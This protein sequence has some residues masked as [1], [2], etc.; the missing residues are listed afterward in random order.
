MSS[1]VGDLPVDEFAA[2]LARGGLAVRIGPFDLRVGARA[3][4]L[5]APLH[6]LYRDYPL[7]DGER[8]LHGH[9][10]VRDVLRWL[11][12]PRRRVRF[13]VDGRAP[14]EDMPAGQALPVLE[15][16]INLVVALRYHCYLMLHAAVLE[17]GGQALLLPAWPGH[18]KTTLCAALAHRGWRLLSDEFGL[19]RPGTRAL[20]PV[21]RPMPLK[22]ESIDVIR[23]FAPEAFLG[24]TIAGTRKGTIAHVRPPAGSVAR[25]QEVAPA[26]WIVFPRWEAGAAL[27]LEEISRSE[28]Y[29]QLATNAFNYE[30]LGEAGFG[31]VRDLIDGAPCHRLVY[32][33]LDEAVAALDALAGAAPK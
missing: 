3:R 28:G 26:G 13:L 12:T 5:A 9:V 15:W 27:Q 20:V 18:G 14:H 31:T 7:L 16:G 29:M 33:D 4:G 6:A 1:R 11:P 17:R 19:V 8:V 23:R 10:E 32:S 24:P 2:R 21:P 22:N 25:A 30:M